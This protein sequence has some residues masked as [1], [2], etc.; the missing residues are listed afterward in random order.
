LQASLSVCFASI[1]DE[2]CHELDIQTG[3]K[4]QS[5]LVKLTKLI[6]DITLLELVMQTLKHSEIDIITCC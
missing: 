2:I 4:G 6:T 1:T 5:N 3:I